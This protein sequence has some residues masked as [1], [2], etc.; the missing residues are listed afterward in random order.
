VNR[1][2]E[3]KKLLWVTYFKWSNFSHITS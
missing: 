3:E 1:E 2:E